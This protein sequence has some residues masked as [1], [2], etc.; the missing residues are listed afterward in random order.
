MEEYRQIT[1]DE[2]TQWKEDI[3]RKLAEP[4]TDRANILRSAIYFPLTGF[5][6]APPAAPP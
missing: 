4:I 6:S 1:L 5:F 2:W 3:R